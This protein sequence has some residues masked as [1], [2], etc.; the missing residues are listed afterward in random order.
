MTECRMDL[1]GGFA[2]LTVQSLKRHK[3]LRHPLML[4]VIILMLL[5]GR[6]SF[7]P[8]VV[9]TVEEQVERSDVAIIG[10]LIKVRKTGGYGQAFGS[11]YL[12]VDK[13]LY[14]DVAGQHEIPI[15]WV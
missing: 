4:C 14:G 10:E 12:R 8:Y 3:L 1:S 5:A 13:G 7:A 2:K 15:Q 11:G 6:T 9:I